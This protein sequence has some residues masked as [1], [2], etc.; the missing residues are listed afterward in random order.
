MSFRTLQRQLA[1]EG[2]SYSRIVTRVRQQMAQQLLEQ[3]DQKLEDIARQLGY[4]NLPNF[5]RAFRRWTGIT[6][7]EYRRLHRAGR[8]VSVTSVVY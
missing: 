2:A 7:G 4:S 6:P 8:P 5:T 3:S 1:R